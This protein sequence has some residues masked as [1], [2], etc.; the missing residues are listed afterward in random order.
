MP[1][2]FTFYSENIDDRFIVLDETEARHASQVLRFQ[3]D[4]NIE[5]SNGLSH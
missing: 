1:G 3:V 5:V 4:D 2:K